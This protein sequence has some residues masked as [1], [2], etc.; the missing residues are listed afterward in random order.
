MSQQCVVWWH[1]LK[2]HPLERTLISSRYQQQL[3]NSCLQQ[4]IHNLQCPW[5]MLKSFFLCF[6]LI[7][8]YNRHTDGAVAHTDWTIRF[9]WPTYTC[10][11]C[12][13]Q[14]TNSAT[15]VWNSVT[16]GSRKKSILSFARA[17]R[18]K[19]DPVKSLLH[20]AFFFIRVL[21][22]LTVMI[23]YLARHIL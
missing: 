16:K 3:P 19:P 9:S 17:Y 20:A 15:K 12:C 1:R 2:W 8:S 6:A 22:T 18:V 5:E 11:H 14:N 21:F 23:L 4:D 13:S 10:M 7:H